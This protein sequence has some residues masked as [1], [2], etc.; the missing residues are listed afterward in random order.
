MNKECYW[1]WHDG[2]WHSADRTERVKATIARFGYP[3]VEGRESDRPMTLPPEARHQ[4]D[5]T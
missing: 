2:E 3:Y 5:S 4:Q 1:Y